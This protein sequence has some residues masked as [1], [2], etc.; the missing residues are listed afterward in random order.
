MDILGGLLIL[1]VI[2]FTYSIFARTKVLTIKEA[3]QKGLTFKYN[4]YGDGINRLNCRSIWIDEKGNE[5][6]VEELVKD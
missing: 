4:V 5:Y 3:E 1:V 2:W 6:R